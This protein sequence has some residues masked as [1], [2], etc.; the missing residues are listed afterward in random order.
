MA[1]TVELQ[2]TGG[3]AQ[4][5]EVKAFIEHALSDKP[6]AWL[7]S[8]LGSQQNDDWELTVEGPNGFARSYTLNGAAGEHQ[9]LKIGQLVRQLTARRA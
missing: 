6:G 8:I 2:N 9:P 5:A 4:R 3:L 1:I 7:V